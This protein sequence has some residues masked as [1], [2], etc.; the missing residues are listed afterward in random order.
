MSKLLLIE[1]ATDVCSVALAADG[2]VVTEVV[3]LQVLSHT[4]LLTNQISSVLTAAQWSMQDVSGIAVSAGPGSYTALR[5]GVSTAKGICYALNIPLIAVN[6]LQA[7]AVGAASEEQADAYISL[8]DARRDEV[9]LAAF[10][11]QF[12]RLQ[13]DQPLILTP[14]N[15]AN[16]MD[17]WDRN[18][19]YERIILAGNGSKKIN[20][21]FFK[22]NMDICGV[23]CCS[24][25]FL[26]HLAHQC[27]EN[28][29]FESL[30]YF[31]PNYMKPPNITTPKSQISVNV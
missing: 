23:E 20:S 15:W 5:T 10:D 9:W 27:W 4:A 18:N 16:W 26:A 19:L 31:E 11:A 14:D 30:A 6:T 22:K 28:G 21:G 25:R 13:S 17:T 2:Q 12:N 24:A 8:I 29:Q 3:A 7:L 1:T